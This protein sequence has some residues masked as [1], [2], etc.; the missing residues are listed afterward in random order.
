MFSRVITR[1]TGTRALAGSGLDTF[2]LD[3]MPERVQRRLRRKIFAVSAATL[4]LLATSGGLLAAD[5]YLHRKYERSSAYNVWGYRGPSRGPKR[6]GEFRVAVLG[7]SAAFGFGVNWDEAMPHHLEQRLNATGTGEGSPLGVANFSV[8]NLAFNSE[9]AAAFRPT[10]ED[11]RFLDYDLAILYEGYNDLLERPKSD[12]FRRGSLIFRWTGYLPVLPMVARERYFEWRYNGDI[13]QGYRDQASA[14]TV[15]RPDDPEAA[16]HAAASL[17]AQLG[18]LSD[19]QDTSGAHCRGDWMNYC[20]TVVD[21]VREARGR[22][23][24]VLVASQPFISDRHVQ[25]QT[26]LHDAI[27]REFGEDSGVRFANLGRTID[28][29]DASL[30]F[31][32]LHLTPEGNR[33]LSLAMAEEVIALLDAPREI[34]R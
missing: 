6:P 7:G 1:T 21:A 32:G 26:A 30:A 34:A 16:R 23:T 27:S 5:L 9:S 20:R 11:Y 2:G 24:L 3:S 19:A 15:F 28:L 12:S 33:R 10:L 22:G 31:D 18:T 17:N 25:Q 29:K 13:A 8:V 4:S 14:Q